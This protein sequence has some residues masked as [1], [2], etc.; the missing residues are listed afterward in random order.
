[1]CPVYFNRPPDQRCNAPE[2]RGRG[3]DGMGGPT[4]ARIRRAVRERSPRTYVAGY[5]RPAF[6]ERNRLAAA[7]KGTRN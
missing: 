3:Q 5:A 1:M 2:S 7:G 4:Y 6:L